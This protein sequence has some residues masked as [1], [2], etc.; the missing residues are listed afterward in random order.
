M[1][2]PRIVFAKCPKCTVGEYY[3]ICSH[4]LAGLSAVLKLS[5]GIIK[6][7]DIGDGERAWGNLNKSSAIPTQSIETISLL[8]S[9]GRLTAYNGL[10]PNAPTFEPR[11]SVYLERIGER[12]PPDFPPTI[13][14]THFGDAVRRAGPRPVARSLGLEFKSAQ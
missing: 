12:L 9:S 14:E 4:I 5:Q 8:T 1:E 13:V 11:M 10:R 2:S 3:P 6:A 7:G